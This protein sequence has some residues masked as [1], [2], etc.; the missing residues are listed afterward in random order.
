MQIDYEVIF[1][2]ILK[3][4]AAKLFCVRQNLKKMAGQMSGNATFDL[5][6]SDSELRMLNLLYVYYY[7]I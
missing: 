7:F 4:L 3:K 6:V 1:I 5:E 2:E